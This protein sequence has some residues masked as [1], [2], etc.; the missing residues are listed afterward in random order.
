MVNPVI[1]DVVRQVQEGADK[2]CSAFV[3]VVIASGPACAR[4]T[5][6][7]HW[8]HIDIDAISAEV[9][10]IFSDVFRQCLDSI[11]SVVFSKRLNVAI[12]GHA[13]YVQEW[14]T[15]KKTLSGVGAKWMNLTWNQKG[16]VW[17]ALCVGQPAVLLA[18]C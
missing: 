13:C 18:C 15:Q 6:P 5:T 12:V 14:D 2:L 8:F 11:I 4:S 10:L 9:L 17:Q 3:L 1:L 7:E 16:L